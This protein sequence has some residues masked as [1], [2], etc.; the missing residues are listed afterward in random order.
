MK[1]QNKIIVAIAPDEQ[2][3]AA[4]VKRIAISM[5]FA[6]TPGDAAKIIRKS[7]HDVN[8][9]ETYFVLAYNY[10]LKESPTTTL[11]L[12]AMA[13]KGIAV[14]VGVKRLPP[15]MEFLCESYYP[16]DFTRL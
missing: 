8:L 4:M 14:V 12:V 15:E 3:R 11:R 16:S 7:P 6:Q 10:N 13:A 1:K 5:G 2:T 9:D